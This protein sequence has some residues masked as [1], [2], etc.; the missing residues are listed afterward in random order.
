[1]PRN[2]GDGIVGSQ[3]LA[4]LAESLVLGSFKRQAFQPL[5][6][7]ANREI[8]AVVTPAPLRCPRMPRTVIGADKLPDDA[9]TGDKKV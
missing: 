9:L 3:V 4:Q 8:I 7:N 1:M 6:F 2:L 5:Q